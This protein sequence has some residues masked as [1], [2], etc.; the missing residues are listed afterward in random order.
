MNKLKYLLILLV[1]INFIIMVY[2]MVIPKIETEDYESYKMEKWREQYIN[3]N[4]GESTPKIDLI[5]FENESILLSNY[6]GVIPTGNVNK[7]FTDLI[8]GGFEK[9]YNETKGLNSSEL[10]KYLEEN[11]EDIANATGITY[12]SDLKDFVNKIQI[13]KD[14][15]L[16]FEK[17]EIIE[18]SYV[19]NSAYDNFKVRISYENGKT[20]DFDVYLSNKDFMETPLVIIL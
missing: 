5:T 14:T 12:I 1:I 19:N 4:V 18:G 6:Y 3:N 16:K 10:E 15:E 11:K 17:I 8:N 20:L 2:L 9:I 13:Y 7:K